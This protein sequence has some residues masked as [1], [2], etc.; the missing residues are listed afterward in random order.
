MQGT[1]IFSE[2]NPMKTVMPEECVD[3]NSILVEAKQILLD[4]ANGDHEF[5]VVT[6]IPR[7]ED[8]HSGELKVQKETV[9]EFS[10][11]NA[12][13]NTFN[14]MVGLRYL[15]AFYAIERKQ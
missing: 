7:C 10:G 15:Q 1:F 2:I 13:A 11:S 9:F 4:E 5:E 8:K 3:L 14:H 6:R 12:L